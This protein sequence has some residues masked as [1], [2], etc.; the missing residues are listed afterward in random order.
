LHGCNDRY[1]T[2]QNAL[3]AAAA[4]IESKK[5]AVW[6]EWAPDS[7]SY[8]NEANPFNSNYQYDFYRGNYERLLEIKNKYDPTAS[9]YVL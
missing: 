8:I 9:L 7:G 1:L 6:R 2:P 4:W 3:S 5:E